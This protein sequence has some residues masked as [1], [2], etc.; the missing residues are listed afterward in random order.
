VPPL[1][2]RG[3]NGL[4]FGVFAAFFVLAALATWGLPERRGRT[5]EELDGS[6]APAPVGA[7]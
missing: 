5:L 3:G 6:P 7:V 1:L 4:V 2:E